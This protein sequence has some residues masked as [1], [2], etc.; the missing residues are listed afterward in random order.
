[1]QIEYGGKLLGKGEGGGEVEVL[2]F[3]SKLELGDEVE[4]GVEAVLQ[5]EYQ[6]SWRGEKN[7]KN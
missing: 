2:R 6:E 3:K 7:M 1:M 4:V 5:S